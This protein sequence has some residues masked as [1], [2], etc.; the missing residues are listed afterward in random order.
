[1]D[2]GGRRRR[3]ATRRRPRGARLGD[4]R[5]AVAGPTGSWSAQTSKPRG[6]HG[7]VLG[8][9]DADGQERLAPSAASGGPAGQVDR[10]RARRAR[11]PAASNAPAGDL[12]AVRRSARSAP[13]A[14]RDRG[15][16]GGSRSSTRPRAQVRRP[17]PPI[18]TGAA[19]ALV[20]PHRGLRAAVGPDQPVEAR[21]CRRWARRRSRRRTPS[22]SV[23][24][25]SVWTRPWSQNSQMKPPWSPGVDS[26]ASQ[27]SA[28]VP[29]LLPIACE[30]SH[31][32]SGCRCS[33]ERAWA[34]IA[35]DRRVHRAGDVADALVARPVEADRALVVERPGRVVAAEPAGGRVVVAR[36]SR[37]RCRAT[38]G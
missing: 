9:R 37:T 28:S 4:G 24:S 17:T 11:A 18:R 25:G 22:A 6:A 27:Y 29:L 12:D 38:R 7:R 34:T 15:S 10:R 16:A 20:L 8:R 1:M 19:S 13:G 23:P 3:A 32:I 26:I 30:Y 31:M 35:D 21:S 5:G 2:A 14:S 33:P 36:R